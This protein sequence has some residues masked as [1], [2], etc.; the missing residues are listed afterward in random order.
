MRSPG[1]PQVDGPVGGGRR[2]AEEGVGGGEQGGHGGGGGGGR[3][4]PG[5]LQPRQLRTDCRLVLSNTFLRPD[6]FLA[7]IRD[8][9]SNNICR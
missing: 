7:V 3:L 6:D 1:G 9:G 8:F 5:A 2:G 4:A